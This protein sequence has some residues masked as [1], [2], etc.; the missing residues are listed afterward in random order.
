MGGATAA[1]AESFIDSE[2]EE[3]VQDVAR[4]QYG[5]LPGQARCAARPAAGLCPVQFGRLMAMWLWVSAV[6]S[7]AVTPVTLRA[8]GCLSTPAAD[9]ALLVRFE[10]VPPSNAGETATIAV[11]AVLLAMSLVCGAMALRRLA[12]T[13]TVETGS[14]FSDRVLS[15]AA[16]HRR[17]ASSNTGGT[18]SPAGTPTRHPTGGYSEQKVAE[19][20]E[21]VASV[22]RHIAAQSGTGDAGWRRAREVLTAMDPT[23]DDLADRTLTSDRQRGRRLA[24]RTVEAMSV[25]PSDLKWSLLRAAVSIA[26][27]DHL[28]EPNERNAI[29]ELI[30]TLWGYPPSE[31]ADVYRTTLDTI[32][33]ARHAA[34][35]GSDE[36]T[37]AEL[38]NRY[39]ALH[40]D[41]NRSG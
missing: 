35:P 16:G 24:G 40:G 8:R 1:A 13:V 38:R 25:L 7:F 37:A 4:K 12:T 15:D 14:P 9:G 32:H 11:A 17:P 27:A 10:C 6:L 20:G 3:R 30:E 18:G 5:P 34:A 31:A 23:F 28:I 33:T 19:V 21:T 2:H 22:L 26:A 41:H 36:P 39:R 29:I